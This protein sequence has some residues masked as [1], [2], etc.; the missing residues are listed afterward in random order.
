[1][2]EL[3]HEFSDDGIVCYFSVLKGP[4]REVIGRTHLD[5][6]LPSSHRFMTLLDG[7]HAA[8]DYIRSILEDQFSSSQ[9][10]LED[11]TMV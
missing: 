10:D 2:E 7:V 5:A 1:M 6:L 8:R 4:V 3:V 11:S 9:N